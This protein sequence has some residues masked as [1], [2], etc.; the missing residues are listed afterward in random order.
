ME[1]N[2]SCLPSASSSCSAVRV[3]TGHSLAVATP[4]PGLPGQ[5]ARQGPATSGTMRRVCDHPVARFRVPDLGR[6]VRLEG[7]QLFEVAHD[8]KC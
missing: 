7:L 8:W 1:V 3:G 6:S 4:S 2:K 5:M